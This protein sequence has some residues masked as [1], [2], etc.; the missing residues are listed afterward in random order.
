MAP[1]ALGLLAL[2]SVGAGCAGTGDAST[3]GRGSSGTGSQPAVAGT[4]G[5]G[6]GSAEG[7]NFG[8][9]G[10]APAFDASVRG[11]EQPPLPTNDM[12]DSPFVLD[13]TA[14]SGLDQATVAMLRTGGS[15]C[16]T[17][18]VYPYEDT[19]FPGGLQSPVIMWQG[20]ADAAYARFEYAQSDHVKYEYAVSAVDPGELQIPR[21]AWNEIAR[22]TNNLYL[23]V[24]LTVQSGGALSTCVLHWRIAPGN[25]VGALYYNTYQAPPP[26]IEGEGAIMRVPLGSTFEIYKQFDGANYGP[27][28]P[29]F[30]CHSL[31][32]D[33]STMVASYHDYFY[34]VFDVE[35]YDVGQAT[36]PSA[37]G[38]IHNA[39]FGA[40]TPDGSR[41]LAMGNPECTQ[42]SETFPRKPNNFPL[43]EGS[44]VARM[45][46]TASGND[47]SAQGLDPNNY[48]WMAQFSPDGDKVVFNHAKPDGAGGTD[49]TQL[50]VM[51]YDYDT[52][53][54]SNLRV[55]V[56]AAM[57][58]APAASL[59]Y[60]PLPSGGGLV[61]EGEN[62]C[63]APDDA[64]D[65]ARQVGTLA[66]GSCSGP[67]YPAWPFFTPDGRAVIFSMVSVPDFAQAFPGRDEP[68]KSD[69]WYVDIETLEVV[70]L[71][72]ANR[73]LRPIDD[74]NNYYP[75][76][77][78]VAVGGYFWL[79]W[80]AVREY[81][82]RV[83]GRDP[84]ALPDAFADAIKKRIWAAAIKPRAAPGG[85]VTATPGPLTDPSLP[86]FYLD[87]Q[88][89]S[90]NV[91]AFA[92][93]NP[94]LPDLSEC[95]TG[96]DCCCGF[97]TIP[98]GAESGQCCLEIPRCSHTNER[99]ETDADCCPPEEG[100]QENECIAGFCGFILVE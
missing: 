19:V 72:R 44:A 75:T 40:L 73:G 9:P 7:L 87:G 34:K 20:G 11:E 36:Q 82:H 47:T 84:N 97:C 13:D 2:W 71:D 66:A 30:S 67:C 65:P 54:F 35:K 58:G 3:T 29:C 96:L 68:S 8:M 64:F 21:E 74:E 90:G 70:R 38:T 14:Q 31:S 25:M 62:A 41:I 95:T 6:T 80:T 45:L 85:E 27:L 43:V 18:V 56:D 46:D 91:R 83:A 49:R 59:D 81:G 50:A 88:S 69:L 92:A 86:G 77:M 61:L 1:A 33:G 99:C 79:F 12:A 28:G 55:I 63:M 37:A 89:A 4:G 32:F 98:E 15:D 100:E 5:G 48:M 60:A 94:C 52:N 22:R 24:T 42:N 16:S 57:M 39:N 17:A 26:G 23:N 76:V 53:T 10:L 51:D 93:L 78:P